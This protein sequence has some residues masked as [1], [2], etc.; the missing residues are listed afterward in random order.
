PSYL[1]I[2]WHS[3]HR[4]TATVTVIEP[5]SASALTDLRS[6]PGVMIAEPF[7]SVPA[8]LRFGHHSRRLSV[9]GLPRDAYL[10]RLLDD[11]ERAVELPPNGLLVSAKL[12]EI[13]GAKV[14]DSIILE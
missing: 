14:G 6:L 4:Q 5:G 13:L 3:A 8:R 7:R 10:N 2:S 12:A 1:S 11:K 9:T